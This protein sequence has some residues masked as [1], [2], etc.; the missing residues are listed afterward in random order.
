MLLCEAWTLTTGLVST[1]PEYARMVRKVD[2]QRIMST[3]NEGGI[4][5]RKGQYKTKA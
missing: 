1:T 4:L 2:R 3:L 5:R